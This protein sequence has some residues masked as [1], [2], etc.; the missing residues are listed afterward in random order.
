[1]GVCVEKHYTGHDYF[2]SPKFYL[3]VHCLLV[4]GETSS[5][6]QEEVKRLPG[7]KIKKKVSTYFVS[8]FC[9][10]YVACNST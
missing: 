6:K 3:F 1:M 5:S 8:V 10:S 4:S 9:Y 7:G 2:C